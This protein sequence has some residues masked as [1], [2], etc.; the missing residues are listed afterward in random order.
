VAL[1]A[2]SGPVA[3]E[4]HEL[5]IENLESLGLRVKEGRHWRG[6]YGF[7]S[8]TDQD[9]LSDLN[10]ALRDPEVRLVVCARGGY[11]AMRLLDGIDWE[12]WKLD[13]KPILGY[14]DITALHC[15]TYAKIG[16]PGWHG[17]IP[18]GNWCE[19]ER[20]S[21]EAALFGPTSYD[22]FAS[23]TRPSS[24]SLSLANGV[25]KERAG[26][27]IGG[28]LLGGNLC[29]VASLCGT[30][31]LPSTDGSILLLEDVG[32]YPYRIDRFLMQLELAGLFSQA[33][34]V[35]VGK[36]EGCGSAKGD[37]SLPAVEE[38]L[39]ERLDRLP[40]PVLHNVDF[41]HLPEKITWPFGAQVELKLVDTPELWFQRG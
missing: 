24:A 40:I 34:A 31:Y 33:R 9:R 18:A 39:R 26:Q 3:S 25:A 29:M 4:K 14:S 2:P 11:G 41:G 35:L 1:I 37:E 16:V 12:S 22:L 6:T 28:N 38:V 15:A 13:P 5:A 23:G 21:L 20:S 17:A 19:F 8:G 7:F 27:S 30:P 36:F 10:E 32:E